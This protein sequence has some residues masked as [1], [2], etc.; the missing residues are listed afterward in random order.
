MKRGTQGSNYED[1]MSKGSL[2]ENDKVARL[3]DVVFRGLVGRRLVI[4]K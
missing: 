2:A 3:T 1:N 4:T